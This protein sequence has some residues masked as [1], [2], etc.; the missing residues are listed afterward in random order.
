MKTFL[1]R[2]VCPAQAFWSAQKMGARTTLKGETKKAIYDILSKK[3]I[4]A[5]MQQN[6]ILDALAK[7]DLQSYYSTVFEQE[8]Y[9]DD[10]IN[11]LKTSIGC[12]SSEYR[13][14]NFYR[15]IVTI[16]VN[17][18]SI[19]VPIDAVISNGNNHIVVK[20][21]WGTCPYA[22]TSKGANYFGIQPEMYLIY[23]AGKKLFGED[24]IVNPAILYTKAKGVKKSFSCDDYLYV[25]PFEIVDGKTLYYEAAKQE[26]ESLAMQKPSMS[27]R[28]EDETKCNNCFYAKLCRFEE[29]SNGSKTEELIENLKK[30]DGKIRF[31][32]DQQKVIDHHEGEA[33]VLAGAGSGKTTCLINR[34]INLVEKGYAKPKDILMI[35]FT[36]KGGREMR[37]KLSHFLKDHSDVKGNFT[38]ETFNSFGQKVVQDSY[39]LLGYE[40]EPYLIDDVLGYDIVTEIANNGYRVPFISYRNPYS[41]VFG[42]KGGLAKI[43][44]AIQLYKGSD[45]SERN[46]PYHKQKFYK[47]LWDTDNEV[48]EEYVPEF[49]TVV[50]KYNEILKKENLIDYA[51]QVGMCIR[52]LENNDVAKKWNYKHIIVDEFQDTSSA[53]MQ[54]VDLLYHKGNGNSLLVCG[55]DAQA[56]FGFRGVGP[57]NILH[58]KDHY[59][60]AIDIYLVDNFRSTNEILYLANKV[61]RLNS[62]Q[63]QKTLIAHK[64]GEVP[65]YVK[66]DKDY[67]GPVVEQVQ[68]AMKKYPLKDIAVLCSTRLEIMKIRRALIELGISSV[69]SVSE[70]YVD[71]PSVIGAM[72]LCAW[73]KDP[74]YRQGLLMY[75]AAVDYDKI[76]ECFNI[77]ELIDEIEKKFLM[78]RNDLDDDQKLAW[79]VD[80]VKAL[81]ETSCIKEVIEIT[82]ARIKSEKELVSFFNKLTTYQSEKSCEQD[83]RAYN[84][85]TISTI[86][87]AKGREWPCVIISCE[88]TRTI[89]EAIAHESGDGRWYATP[90]FDDERIRL[91]YVAITRAKE[92]L[93]I[94][95]SGDDTNLNE[96]KDNIET[97]M[98]SVLFNKRVPIVTENGEKFV[99][100]RKK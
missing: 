61:I 64:T 14:D 81:P 32:D 69:M 90:V 29:F 37:E 49:L 88:K 87:A 80:K 43:Y 47:E 92:E 30:S 17:G 77:S 91:L 98:I 73:L 93:T 57:E 99:P 28:C 48:Y 39:K 34:T 94:V 19:N 82:D 8:E 4:N 2:A 62:N 50:E 68:K 86:H 70:K 35:T 6:T 89:K 72:G 63:I 1:K 85:I 95:Q 53:Q 66:V 44:D 27:K 74:A 38:I 83:D 13:F 36:E 79:T 45:D 67:C 22:K 20:M 76:K 33:R 3:G 21:E 18:N 55:D 78:E 60:E 96:L 59:P 75:Q 23:L 25:A 9:E 15:T 16:D 31:T 52:L 11:E 51:D 58:F 40:N 97:G 7:A 65:V 54:I 56:I 84:A 5:L 24:A 100:K 41:R 12:V 71:D 26:V 46:L 10:V 42:V